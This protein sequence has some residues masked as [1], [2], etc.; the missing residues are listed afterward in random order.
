VKGVAVYLYAFDVAS[1]IK[2][3]L[4]RELLS[5]RP[6]PFQI[7]QGRTVPR[8]LPVYRPLTIGLNPAEWD[9]SVGPITL[10]SF[11]K[12]FDFGV[13]SISYEVAFEVGRIG[14]LVPYHQ[15]QVGD[16]TLAALAQQL[17]GHVSEGLAPHL[18]KPS[19][20]PRE[21]EAYT[22]FCFSEVE[23]AADTAA[24]WAARQRIDL[25]GLLLEEPEPARLD[26]AQIDESFR[27]TLSYSKDDV[28]V[29]DWDA[30][31]V[32]ERTGYFDDVL[33][34]LE[35]A[36]LQL[37]QFRL[38]DDRLDRFIVRSYDDLEKYYASRRFLREPRATLATLR[39]IR[40]DVSKISEEA[41][42]VTKFVGDWYLARIYLACKDRFYLGHW[43]QSVD[44]KLRQLDE[45]YSMV[46]AEIQSRRMMV[47]EAVIIALF[48]LDL[49][50]VFLKK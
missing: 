42:N 46:H 44:Q 48:L 18:V 14:E 21:P 20:D 26:P 41:T 35:L 23:G 30:A 29:I 38:L 28:A 2:T 9:S 3:A 17:A 1:E 16:T 33:Y 8:D 32:V 40:M 43:D 11:V 27:H 13:V 5:K 24:A 7:R 47:M 12:I 19:R 45:L 15:L 39:T 22:A 10:K 34:V 31:V 49:L 37:E 25:A 4:V 50:L 6:F 36:N